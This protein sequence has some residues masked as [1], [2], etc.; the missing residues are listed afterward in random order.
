MQGTEIA[1]TAQA[2]DPK[3]RW[4]R[5]ALLNTSNK[6]KPRKAAKLEKLPR[7]HF[8]GSAVPHFAFIPSSFPPSVRRLT[9]HRIDK[10][11]V[12]GYAPL[13]KQAL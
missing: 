2:S 4:G 13:P 10:E 12:T 1:E 5:Y 7:I 6:I 9:R 8:A 3:V 11:L